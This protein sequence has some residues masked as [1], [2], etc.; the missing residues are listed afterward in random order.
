MPLTL[1]QALDDFYEVKRGGYSQG[2]WRSI[3]GRLEDYRR[4]ITKETQPNV[5]LADVCDPA[6][7]YTER[8]FNKIRPPA[9]APSSFNLYRQH[10][11]SFWTY[12]RE[13][14]WVHTN[15]M[16]H[17]DALRV[18]R[19]PKLLLSAEELIELLN[20]T[21]NPRDRAAIAIGMNT[22]LRAADIMTLKVGDVNFMNDRI[23]AWI[24]KTDKTKIINITAELRLELLR[25]LNIYA[26]NTGKTVRELPNEWFLIP[27]ARSVAVKPL[28]PELGRQLKYQPMNSM[29]RCN[30]ENIVKKALQRCGH[31][32]VKGQG[33][34][35][36]RRGSGRVVYDLARTDGIPDPITMAQSF[37]DHQSRLTTELYLGVKHADEELSGMMR[38]QSFL[39]RAAATDKKRSQDV[40]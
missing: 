36:T 34:H 30:P 2:S 29:V 32:N 13:R 22:G 8:Y 24:E 21:D 25:W 39:T 38:G 7:R 17:I 16:M 15:P 12:T 27:T 14:G 4:W 3:L 20:S 35:T 11:N 10:L 33:F 26:E 37:Y 6:V 1:N 28:H 23:T 40:A 18:P 31:I 5:Y 9:Y 19:K